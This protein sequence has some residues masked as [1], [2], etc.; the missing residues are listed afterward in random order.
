[1]EI[2]VWGGKGSNSSLSSLRFS[3]IQSANSLKVK[4]PVHPP[5]THNHHM[6]PRDTP[7]KHTGETNKFQMRQDTS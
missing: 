6:D 5:D 4:L 3:M 1:M 7:I 2:S